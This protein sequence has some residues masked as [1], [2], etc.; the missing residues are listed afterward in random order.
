MGK[1][2]S[3]WDYVR[4]VEDHQKMQFF[5]QLYHKKEALQA[6]EELRIPQALHLIWL[7]PSPLPKESVQ[8]LKQWKTLH[9][10]WEL[11]LWTDL[12]RDVPF[13][14]M[15]KR[16]VH[17]LPFTHLFKS[18]NKADNFKEK[19]FFLSLEV[20]YQEGGLY[21]DHD[22]EPKAD[23]SKL[24][25]SLDF[26]A[27]LAPLKPSI[28]SSSVY[29][30]SYLLASSKGHLVL[31]SA[32]RH[33]QSHFDRYSTYFPGSRSVDVMHRTKQLMYDALEAGVEE[34]VAV[35]TGREL[36]FP[37]AEMANLAHH[38]EVGT[39]KQM[40]TVEQTK[41]RLKV[42]ALTKQVDFTLFLMWG[43][44]ALFVLSVLQYL[45]RWRRA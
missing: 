14:G 1:G 6:T 29:P 25:H 27:P 2:T 37:A 9:P 36:F 44:G 20:L 33:I 13:K 28:F 40:E 42:G 43:V 10:E 8:R 35:R 7:G 23:F 32:M 4:T 18:Y 39:W 30:E 31:L 21:V 41:L 17:E 11:N 3:S 34:G 19:A 16:F 15:K 12:D 26:Y 22:V 5:G 24:H 45:F 38:H